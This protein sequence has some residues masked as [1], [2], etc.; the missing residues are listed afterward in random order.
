MN[1]MTKMICLILAFILSLG[2]L[3]ACTP[4]EPGPSGESSTPEETPFETDPP[5][6]PITISADYTV[7]RPELCSDATRQA[8]VDITNALSNALGTRV[9]IKDDFLFG[10]MK[11]AELE[12]LVG[13][14]NRE[15]S[16]SVFDGL[17]YNDYSISIEGRKLVIAAYTDELITEAA[18][19][20]IGLIENAADAL[21]FNDEDQKTVCAEYPQPTSPSAVIL[22]KI[23]QL[24]FPPRLTT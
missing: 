16:E 1:N 3:A 10:D 21:T 22:L 15:E 24:F 11:P 13:L 18:T 20:V 9:S 23:T 5:K 19:Y 14:T 6:D 2:M 17:K 8:A 4:A 7:V 12:I